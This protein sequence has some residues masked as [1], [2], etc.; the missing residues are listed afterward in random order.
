[1][2][3]ALL[4]SKKP[5]YVEAPD[6]PL[7]KLGQV[8]ATPSAIDLLRSLALNPLIF[9]AR[10]SMGDWGNI[11]EH[12]RQANR[13]ALKNGSRLMSSY[14]VTRYDRLA[15]ITAEDRSSTTLLLP[16]EY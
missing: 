12:D 2:R 1:M 8:V 5:I 6:F 4:I 11:D 3:S 7:F 9:L 14:Q 16:M 15:I 13:D 10:H